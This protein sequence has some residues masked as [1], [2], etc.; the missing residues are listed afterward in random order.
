MRKITIRG[1]ASWEQSRAALAT[2]AQVIDR[3]V[4]SIEIS[5]VAFGLSETLNHSAY[6]CYFLAA[7]IG[8]GILVTADN[9]FVTKCSAAGFG[10]FVFSIGDP[11][12]NFLLELAHSILSWSC[13]G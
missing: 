1:E 4:P 8:K 2:V 7:A 3:F 9:V 11:V 6:D 10:Q 13:L 12:A 5:A